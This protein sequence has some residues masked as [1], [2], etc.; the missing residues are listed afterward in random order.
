MGSV[1]V[2]IIY[3]PVELMLCTK[4]RIGIPICCI[5]DMYVYSFCS[6]TVKYGIIRMPKRK[7]HKQEYIPKCGLENLLGVNNLLGLG[8]AEVQSF[9]Q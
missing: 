4:I 8:G 7:M 2:H 9:I 6:G 5:Y 3:F 1:C